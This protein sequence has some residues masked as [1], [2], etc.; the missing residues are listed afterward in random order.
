MKDNFLKIVIFCFHT[1]YNYVAD[2]A[3]FKMTAV[4]IFQEIGKVFITFTLD[5]LF[6]YSW[7]KYCPVFSNLVH[8]VYH[9]F[10]FI[11]YMWTIY[12]LLN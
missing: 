7:I 8:H 9:I 3:V 12:K 6:Y 1:K 4:K 5:N 10:M 11:I 2:T